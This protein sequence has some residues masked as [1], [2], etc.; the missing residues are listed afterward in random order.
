M[1]NLNKHN[2]LAKAVKV[3][4]LAASVASA[5]SAPAVFAAEEDEAEGQKI[6]VTGSRIKRVA[7]EGAQPVTIITREELD[8]SGDTSVADVLRNQSA[9]SFGSWKGQSG[10][11]A[12]AT[13]SAEINL[14]GVGATL[15]LVDGRRLPG[16]GYD[17][18]ATQN[19]NNIPLAIVERIEILRGGA[20]AIYG[21]DAVA[22]VV[23][24]IT[25]TE[26]SGGSFSV[27]KENR[28]IDDGGKMKYEFAAGVSGDKGSMLIVAEHTSID[29]LEDNSVTGFDNGVSWWSPVANTFYASQSAGAYVSWFEDTLCES[30]PNTVNQ[31]FRCGYA[32][33]N[34]TW[35]YPQQDSDSVWAKFDYQLTENIKFNARLGYVGTKTHSRFAPTPVSTNSVTM[36]FDN[37]NAP[38]VVANDIISGFDPNIYIYHRTAL[39]GNRD[40]YFEDSAFDLVFGLEGFLNFGEGF[41]WEVNYQRTL[42]DETL[43]NENLIN[44]VAFQNGIDNGDFDIFNVQGRTT[45]AWSQH[46]LDFYQSVAHTGIFKVNQVKE[47]VDGN[48]SGE[49]FSNESMT[50]A[51]VAGGEY[52]TTDFTQVSDPE[53]GQGF[54]SGGSGGDDVFAKRDRT[55][56]YS[57]FALDFDFGLELSAAVRY[58]NYDQTGDV[59]LTADANRSFS[60]TTTMFTAAYRPTDDLLIRAVVGEA[61]RAPTMPELFA[62][63][64]FGFPSGYDYYYCDTQGNAST[65]GAY[66]DAT[67]QPQHLVFSGGN[68]T[69][70]PEQ[71]DTVAAGVVWSPSDDLTL[72]WGYY[73][74]K[75]FNKIT[76]VSVNDILLQN[77][78][79]GGNTAAVTRGAN[80]QIASIQ[81]GSLNLDSQET[82][83]WDFALRYNL[84]TSFGNF[85]FKPSV[86]RVIDF[87]NIDTDSNGNVIRQNIA[88]RVDLPEMRANILTS[89]SMEDF[90]AAWQINFIKGQPANGSAFVDL[91]DT[92]YHNLQVGMHTA[93][94]GE[95]TVGVRNVL[96]EQIQFY[97]G[98]AAWRNFN[99]TLYSPEGRT[100]FFRY[101][102]S[103]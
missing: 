31:G 95:V 5:Y 71:G 98:Q 37:P 6:L 26:I 84:E 1:S 68:P 59:G 29:E 82:T 4:L 56:V 91:K 61:F 60:D 9:N 81:G 21:S 97:T 24:I 52:E 16:V 14:R 8:L 44:D 13:G 93:W 7:V 62:S 76:S 90:Y 41:D 36:Q 32:Y 70:E 51:F 65:A 67:N 96:D 92:Y 77:N 54:I 18:G 43:L 75:Y 66:C 102:Q 73:G 28:G 27:L 19:L 94:N 11:G 23:N 15:V 35:L 78:A 89:W 53:S 85:V 40:A 17:G 55:S 20:S 63:Q 30:V 39:L 57:E 79:Q 25:R 49:I 33:S 99:T 42:K 69:L 64:S 86:S 80:G 50:L 100:V 47:I 58:D 48:I 87:V 2:P 88:N 103:F 10:F 3:A 101:K 72:E 12:G 74:I 22:G 34:V 46:A 83:G 38:A 45:A